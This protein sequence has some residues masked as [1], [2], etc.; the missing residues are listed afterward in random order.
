MLLLL[1][2]TPLQALAGLTRGTSQRT[3]VQTGVESLAMIPTRM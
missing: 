2:T 3:L 1:F